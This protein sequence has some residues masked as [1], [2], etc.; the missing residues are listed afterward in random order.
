VAREV[1]R[2]PVACVVSGLLAGSAVV[3]GALL[4]AGLL[5]APLMLVVGGGAIVAGAVAGTAGA[6]V[7]L[8]GAVLGPGRGLR[9][10]RGFSAAVVACFVLLAVPPLFR[11]ALVGFA[12][13]G[14]GATLRASIRSTIRTTPGR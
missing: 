3:V 14:L 8:G 9:R 10:A 7:A 13:L 2:H 5:G 1:A 6:L 11:A 12:A 4:L